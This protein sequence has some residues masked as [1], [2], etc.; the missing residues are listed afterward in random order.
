MK[1]FLNG[2][3]VTL[4]ILFFIQILLV[5]YLFIVDPY[6][7]KPFLFGSDINTPT[8]NQES[9]ATTRNNSPTTSQPH[10]QVPDK[11][12][13]LNQNQEAALKAVGIDPAAIPTQVSAEQENCF[14]ATIGQERVNEIKAGDIPTAAEIFAGRNCL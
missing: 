14:E 11:N 6:N 7:L 5:A 1:K 10:E 3:F 12:P 13:V 2:F 8:S 4:G 9:P